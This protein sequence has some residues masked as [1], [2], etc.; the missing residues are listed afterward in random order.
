[1]AHDLDDHLHK[2]DYWGKTRGGINWR[3][4]VLPALVIAAIG[5]VLFLAW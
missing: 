2:R 4:L 5:A 3:R 1:M